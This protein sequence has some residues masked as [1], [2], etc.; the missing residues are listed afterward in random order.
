MTHREG[1]VRSR[2]ALPL[3]GLRKVFLYFAA[4]Q[5][6]NEGMTNRTAHTTALDLAR[7]TWE[8]S[9]KTR[10]DWVRYVALAEAI[11]R[12]ARQGVK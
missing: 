11:R 2:R 5:G 9:A 12:T 7:R 3:P 10:L 1:G 8:A 6:D 4:R